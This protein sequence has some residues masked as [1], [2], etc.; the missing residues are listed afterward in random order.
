M[1]VLNDEVKTGK[2]FINV[3]GSDANTDF[4]VAVMVV[5]NF[6]AKESCEM[7]DGETLVED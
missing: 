4:V 6:L 5:K 3:Q 1:L 2:N 7:K